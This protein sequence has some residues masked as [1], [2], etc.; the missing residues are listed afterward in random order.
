ME[1]NLLLFRLI[2]TRMTSFFSLIFTYSRVTLIELGETV[3]YCNKLT[4]LY[5]FNIYL[6]TNYSGD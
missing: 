5:S 6:L 4:F 1:D 2:C 3:S